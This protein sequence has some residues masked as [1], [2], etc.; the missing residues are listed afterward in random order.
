M[1]DALASRPSPE[2]SARTR[3]TGMSARRMKPIAFGI[4]HGLSGAPGSVSGGVS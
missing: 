1:I 3:K 4:V 2:L